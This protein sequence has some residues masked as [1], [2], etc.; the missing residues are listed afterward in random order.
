MSCTWE[1]CEA[2]LH[3]PEYSTVAHQNRFVVSL[4]TIVVGGIVLVALRPPFVVSARANGVHRPRLA[5]WRIA[6]ISL[7]LGAIVLAGPYI[8]R[9]IA[10]VRALS[11]PPQAAQ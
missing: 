10:H 3:N 2:E 9:A 7:G 8:L 11:G 1:D 6:L 5:W 4:V